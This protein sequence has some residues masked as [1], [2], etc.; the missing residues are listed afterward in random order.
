MMTPLFS[1]EPTERQAIVGPLASVEAL[2]NEYIEQLLPAQRLGPQLTL[3][4]FLLWAKKR[5]EAS[6]NVLTF[7][8]EKGAGDGSM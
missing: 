2:I 3:S 7:R 4:A 8:V 1:S 6:D 5:Q